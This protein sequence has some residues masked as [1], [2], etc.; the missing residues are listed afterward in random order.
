MNEIITAVGRA[1]LVE[2]MKAGLGDTRRTKRLQRIV[3][4][5]VGNPDRPFPEV[6]D[7]PSDLEGLYRFV[8]NQHLDFDAV[9]APHC[10]ATVRR[11]EA[12]KEV[13]VVHDSTEFNFK[14]YGDG[15]RAHLCRLSKT[16]QGFFGHASLVVSADGLRA[17][18]GSAVS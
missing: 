14:V 9:L 7:Q 3:E 11:A 6:F 16:R 15:A 4:V 13:L 8:R 18:L 2:E 12:Q 10:E 5:L 17:P 1:L